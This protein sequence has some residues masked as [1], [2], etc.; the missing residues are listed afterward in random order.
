MNIFYDLMP[1]WERVLIGF[2]ND[3]AKTGLDHFLASFRNQGFTDASL[4]PWSPVKD[5][6]RRGQSILTKTGRLRR[7]L[8]YSVDGLE[9]QY[10]NSVPYAKIHNEGGEIDMPERKQIIHFK[11]AGDKKGH[12]FSRKKS[13]RFAQK[14]KVGAYVIKMPKRMFMGESVSMF[15]KMVDDFNRNVTKE[16]GQ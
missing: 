14:V 8:R 4:Q 7:G 12:V 1:R 5:K 10:T 13:A 16:F 15:K 2:R 6:K 3:A 9:I 11:K